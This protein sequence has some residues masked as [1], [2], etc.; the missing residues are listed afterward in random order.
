MGLALGLV[1]AGG[2]EFMDDRLHDE[3]QIKALLP[4]AVI[5]EV[6]EIVSPFDA[7]KTRRSVAIGWAATAIV[8]VSLLAG[9]VFSY[10]HN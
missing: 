4:V 1:V 6:P 10:L 8:F 2:F 7:Q 3:K 5:S 9:S